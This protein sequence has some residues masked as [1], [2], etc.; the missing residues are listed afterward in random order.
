MPEPNFP[1]FRIYKE[2]YSENYDKYLEDCKTHGIEPLPKNLIERATHDIIL[3]A[4]T[5]MFASENDDTY[6]VNKMSE[7]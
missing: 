2:Y 6:I 4:N 7:N 1:V 3:D 5:G